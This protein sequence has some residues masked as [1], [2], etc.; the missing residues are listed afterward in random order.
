VEDRASWLEIIDSGFQ[1]VAQGFGRVQAELTPG[2]YKARTQVGATVREKVFAV[3]E[4]ASPTPVRL[5]SVAFPSPAPLQGT[6]TSHEY[7]QQAVAMAVD[8]AEPPIALGTGA[9][10]L[11]SVRDPSGVPFEQTEQTQDAYAHSFDGFSLCAA[12]GSELINYDQ[13]A[14]RDVS[15]GFAIRNAELNP[16]RYFLKHQRT[17]L[18]PVVIPI[19]TVVGWASQIFIHLEE[20]RAAEATHRPVL[21]EAA[22]M[23]VPLGQP[24]HPGDRYFRLT[25]VARQALQ[26]GR[27][28]L[29][30]E[31]MN[32]LLGSKFGNPVLGLFAA[33]LLLLDPKPSLDLLHI[34][35][36]N[37]GELLGWDFPDVTILRRRLRQLDPAASPTA[38][39]QSPVGF[40]PLL[41]ASW[42]IISSLA[43]A[44]ETIFPAGS[45]SWQVADRL[46]DNGIWM[47]WRPRQQVDTPFGWTMLSDDELQGKKWRDQ[48]RILAVFDQTEGAFDLD[49][50]S[51]LLKSAKTWA[52]PV[53]RE[54]LRQFIKTVAHTDHDELD[55]LRDLVVR[56]AKNYPW[57]DLVR[58]LTAL[59]AD[60]EISGRLS[61]VQKSLIPALMMVRQQLGTDE[62]INQARWE[63]LLDSLQVPRSVLLENLSDL[64][65]LAA[66]LAVRLY[67]E[68]LAEVNVVLAHPGA[69]KKLVIQEIRAATGLGLKAAR[70]I[71][72]RVPSP[73]KLSISKIEAEELKKQLEKAGATVRLE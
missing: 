2:L 23:M 40:P 30:R 25:E 28:I 31:L 47:A 53:L 72:N 9:S 56:L 60:G 20:S 71:V 6:T 8:H 29:D 27:N 3:D 55:Q 16:G 59:D 18:E 35:V 37:L 36:D 73:V 62:T 12:D 44:D 5:A 66:G 33:H 26:Q 7:H 52:K 51:R 21:R 11:L 32:D 48:E 22:V 70:E 38:P 15:L 65:R 67:E 49:V 19:I 14:K 63:Q 69:N 1:M 58:K 34:V 46:I 41:R 43:V 17:D 68:T 13:A 45:V 4:G 57:E 42:A 24:F 64:A 10:L 61:S 39:I 54:K 50:G